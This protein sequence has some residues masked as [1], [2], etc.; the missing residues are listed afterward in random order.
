VAGTVKA[1]A[2][3]AGNTR[4]YPL[5]LGAIV[6]W[7][8]TKEAIPNG[9]VLC[10]GT[11]TYNGKSVP[12]LTDRFI[13]GWVTDA[14]GTTPASG[15]IGYTGGA[16]TGTVNSGAH[17]HAGGGHTHQVNGGGHSHDVT[18]SHSSFN[19]GNP[20]D[21]ETPPAT[22][23]II[24][25]PNGSTLYTQ[26]NTHDHTISTN[27]NHDATIVADNGSHHT[28]QGT[29]NHTHGGGSHNHTWDNEP[30]YYVLAFIIKVADTSN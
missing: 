13:K 7:A 23:I 29:G 1:D 8:G 24:R 21:P 19:D 30:E 22:Q 25:G 14:T 4:L 11:T 18:I 27:H 17:N 3:M 28:Q 9:F 6:M 26:P 2:L 15:N 10:D 12:D 16:N 5:P 20:T